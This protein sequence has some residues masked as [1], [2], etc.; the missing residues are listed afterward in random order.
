MTA[1]TFILGV[2]PLMIATGPGAEM[3]QALGTTVFFGMLGVTAFGLV[4]TPV[5]YVA[6]RRL[7]ARRRG[8]RASGRRT[9]SRRH[10]SRRIVSAGG[11]A[12]TLEGAGYCRNARGT[13]RFGPNCSSSSCCR[14][15]I[16]A[17]YSRLIAGSVN[18]AI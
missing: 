10:K 15:A 14:W 8:T 7:F 13:E 3:R 1:F 9:P 11:G 18:R 12:L 5:F 17:R 16:R 6:L 2:V 4:L